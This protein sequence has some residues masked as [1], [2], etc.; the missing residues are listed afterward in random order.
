V[1]KLL[2]R[3]PGDLRS[4]PRLDTVGPHWKDEKS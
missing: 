3:E 4:G 2:V 1:E